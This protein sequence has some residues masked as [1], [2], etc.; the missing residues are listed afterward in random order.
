MDY[1][2]PQGR[3]KLL[4]IVHDCSLTRY[5]STVVT[6]IMIPPLFSCCREFRNLMRTVTK[7]IVSKHEV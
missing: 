5:G 7:A 4:Y 1:V 6:N 3:I 2:L